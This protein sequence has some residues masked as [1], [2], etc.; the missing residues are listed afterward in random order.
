MVSLYISKIIF[1]KLYSL[2]KGIF[3]IY[4]SCLIILTIG[5]HDGICQS[6]QSSTLKNFENLT[7]DSVTQR[8]HYEQRLYR[9]PAVGL[10]ELSQALNKPSL[11]EYVPYFQGVP[12]A[13]YSL[14]SPFK[15]TLFSHRERTKLNKV[16]PFGQ[17]QYKFDFRI[18][19][20]FIANFGYKPDALQSK[21]SLLLQSQLYLLQGL[22]LNWGVL[23]PLVNNYDT[24]P[25][26]I[27]PAPVYLNQFLAL[28]KR[29]FLSTS[30]GLFYNNQYGFNVQYR[31]ANL[32]NAWSFGLET[33]LTG[34]YYFPKRGIYCEPLQRFMLLADVAYRVKARDITL[35]L[36]G[37][38]YLYGDQGARLDFI[39]QFYSVEI[40]LYATMTTRGSTAGFNFAIPIPP[41]RLIQSQR[42][43]VRTSEEFR[44]EYTYNGEANVGSRYRVGYQLDALLRQ[45]HT[46]Y[47]G[48]QLRR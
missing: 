4:H 28:D 25:M 39:R 7:V 18:H 29:N 42:F 8:V 12:I 46:N 33:S 6:D 47:I 10:L 44:W 43:R 48:G 36:S 15:T 2:K 20:E 24:Q 1:R 11:T 27:R 35:K 30:A 17:R 34:D 3:F 5:I 21:T 16:Y 40:G 45:Y 38:Q 22:V 13:A 41:G 19:P 26:N 32:T 23:F 9:N 14:T 37:G 31:W